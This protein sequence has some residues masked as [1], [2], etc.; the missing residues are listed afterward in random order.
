MAASRGDGRDRTFRSRRLQVAV[1]EIDVYRNAGLTVVP[2][3]V[4]VKAHGVGGFVYRV[5]QR[6]P[7]V[8]RGSRCRTRL[9]ASPP[10]SP[11]ARHRTRSGSALGPC[12]RSSGGERRRSGSAGFEAGSHGRAIEWR[13]P[14]GRGSAARL[15]RLQLARTPDAR[16]SHLSPAEACLSICLSEVL[17]SLGQVVHHPGID[18]SDRQGSVVLDIGVHGP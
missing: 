8:R 1:P 15:A 2:H 5:R 11:N 4:C 18:R 10:P 12:V 7:R 13:L 14:I 6:A 3:F 9:P 16:P 17:L